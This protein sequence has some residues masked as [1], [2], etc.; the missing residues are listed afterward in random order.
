MP[1]CPMAS[2]G[3]RLHIA[4]TM[5]QLSERDVCTKI[6]SPAIE[7][8]GW[9]RNTQYREEVNLTSGRVVVRGNKG[10]RDV[11]TIRRADYVL[12][13]KPGIPLAVIEAKDPKHTVRDGMQQALAYAEMLDVPFAFSSN[14]DGFVFHDRSGGG[15]DVEIEIDLADFPSPDALWQHFLAWK[16]IP[17]EAEA[18]Y[19][20]DYDT[21]G[22]PARY[23]QLAAVNRAVG[24]VARGQK[25]VLLVMAT[26]CGKTF[27]AFQIIWRLWKSKAAIDHAARMR[28]ALI[29]A[30]PDLAT[31]HPQYCMQIT[32]DNAEAIR[33]L[34]RCLYRSA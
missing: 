20:Q 27:T 7:A 8:A 19:G 13:Y 29:N 10:K 9:D 18:V 3:F 12:Y 23:Y 32:G 14:G 26:G 2:A 24:A 5:T 21:L 30:N 33:E 15:G 4:N 31:Q 17:E 28:Q 34:E 11:K 6:I 25:R 1:L 22:R 16:G